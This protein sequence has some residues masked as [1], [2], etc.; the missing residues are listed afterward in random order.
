MY[1][2]S[3]AVNECGYWTD[4]FKQKEV[5]PFPDRIIPFWQRFLFAGLYALDIIYHCLRGHPI[6]ILTKDECEE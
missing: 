2:D 3:D 1:K 5:D 4:H 6:K